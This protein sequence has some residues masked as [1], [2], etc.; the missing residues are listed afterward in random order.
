MLLTAT[1]TNVRNRKALVPAV[2]SYG[3]RVKLPN[4]KELG[5]WIPLRVDMILL[6]MNSELRTERLEE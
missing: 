4:R 6:A 1:V 2:N 3:G 5:A